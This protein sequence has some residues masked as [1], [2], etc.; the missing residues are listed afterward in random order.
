MCLQDIF[1]DGW[2][3]SDRVFCVWA[4]ALVQSTGTVAEKLQ[5]SPLV[6]RLGHFYKVA[7][8]AYSMAVLHQGPPDAQ[9]AAQRR[10]SANPGLWRPRLHAGCVCCSSQVV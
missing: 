6:E 10:L 5:H 9:S 8:V 4:A 1:R 7:A 2:L 3:P